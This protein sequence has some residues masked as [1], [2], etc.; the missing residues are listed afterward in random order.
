VFMDVHY[1]SI[2]TLHL[3]L[4]SVEYNVER[5][6]SD[7]RDEVTELWRQLHNVEL[8]NVYRSFLVTRLMKSRTLREWMNEN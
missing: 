3:V 7:L 4:R 2:I 8:H 1:G 6:I 5:I